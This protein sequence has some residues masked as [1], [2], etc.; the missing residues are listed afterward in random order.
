MNCKVTIPYDLINPLG[1]PNQQIQWL[2]MS[3]VTAWA[4]AKTTAGKTTY[5]IQVDMMSLDV[6]KLVVYK[7]WEVEN[8]PLRIEVDDIQTEAP[9]ESE[10]KQTRAER[11]T[12]EP[13]QG[14]NK[15][16]YISTSNGNINRPMSELVPVFDKLVSKATFVSHMPT[17]E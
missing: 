1:T 6:A 4:S 5:S 3:A 17:N 16:R 7:E 15:K 8:L 10:E 9:F 12:H 14:T 13:V 11:A 2:A